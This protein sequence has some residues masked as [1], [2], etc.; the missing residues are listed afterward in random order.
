MW[1]HFIGPTDKNEHSFVLHVIFSYCPF[2]WPLKAIY[3]TC[4]SILTHFHTLMAEVAVGGCRPA[5]LATFGSVSCSRILLC[6]LRGAGESI[7]WPAHNW[8]TRFTSWA[9]VGANKHNQRVDLSDDWL[10]GWFVSMIFTK[11]FNE[12][13]VL[14]QNRTY[15]IGSVL[16]DGSW[17]FFLTFYEIVFFS[18]FVSS[19]R[20]TN[21]SWWK[22][23]AVFR[24][25]VSVSEHKRGP[26]GLGGGIFSLFLFFCPWF[27]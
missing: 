15:E 12:G 21:R 18:I 16:R 11:N 23:S 2:Y 13:Q 3:H 6:A 20:I 22:K 25:L 5:H 14:A 8:T 24:R 26:L 1:P 4:S 17:N 7:K 10:I 27:N 19:Q 9:T